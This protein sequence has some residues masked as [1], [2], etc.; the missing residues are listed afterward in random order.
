MPAFAFKGNPAITLGN[1]GGYSQARTGS[2]QCDGP[3]R[4][5]LAAPHLANLVRLQFR[6]RKRQGS[7]VVENEKTVEPQTA[8]RLLN[9]KCPGAIGELD[10][11]ASNRGGHVH[12]RLGNGR[13]SDLV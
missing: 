4:Y 1:E 3:S 6:Q 9:G 12:G 10:E 11:I 5:S 13:T 7:E 8:A 2:Q